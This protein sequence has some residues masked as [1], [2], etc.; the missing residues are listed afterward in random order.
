MANVAV[1]SAGLQR[2]GQLVGMAE[3][4]EKEGQLVGMAGNDH[5][6]RIEVC[7]IESILV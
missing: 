4:A 6:F 2:E 5:G 3:M 7:E 1:A